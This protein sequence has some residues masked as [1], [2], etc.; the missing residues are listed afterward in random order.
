MIHN[1]FKPH[2][3][4]PAGA[5]K[6]SGMREEFSKLSAWVEENVPNGRERSIV[7]THLQ[8]ASMHAVRGIAEFPENQEPD[9]K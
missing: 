5:A 8:D 6:V 1:L 9:V 2:N 4:N 7:M 3:L